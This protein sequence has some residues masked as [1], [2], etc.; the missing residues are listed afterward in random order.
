MPGFKRAGLP[1]AQRVV[2]RFM[3]RRVA[4]TVGYNLLISMRKASRYGI[5]E[6]MVVKSIMST[7]FI[8][9]ISF[10]RHSGCLASS[11]KD[12]QRFDPML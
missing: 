11:I 2:S 5:F 10:V 8:S 6:L 12:Q 9:V 3:T 4:W 7:E 1:L